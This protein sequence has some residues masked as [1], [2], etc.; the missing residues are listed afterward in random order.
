MA[1]VFDTAGERHV[2]GASPLL[3]AA[4]RDRIIAWRNGRGIRVSE[5]LDDIRKVAGQL[6]SAGCAINLCE[7]RYGFIVAFCAVASK[8]QATLLPTSRAN[9]AIAD[10]QSDHPGA[11]LVGDASC[12]MDLPNLIRLPELGHPAFNEGAPVPM[13]EDARIVAIGFTSGSTG[14]PK[15][16]TK[17]WGNFRLSSA[18]NIDAIHAATGLSAAQTTHVLATVPAQHMYGMEMSVLLPLFGNFAVHSGKAFF[19]ADVAHSLAQM[20]EPRLLVTTPVHLRALLHSAVELPSITAFI[21]ATAPLTAELANEVEQRFGAPVIELFGSTETCV[22]A[23]RRTAS[24]SDWN[25]YPNVELVAQADGTRVEASHLSQPT[26]LQDILELRSR[27]RFRL[28][29]RNADLLEI[30]GKRASL[31]DLTHRLLGLDGVLDAVVFQVDA[32]AG[33]PVRRIAALAVAPGRSEKEL[34]GA[35]RKL[36]DPV[37]LP[38]PLRLVDAL[39]RNETGKLPRQALISAISES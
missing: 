20:P 26:L 10:V 24:E 1:A 33:S 16:N 22:I 31:A 5:F 8:G 15:P 7:D 34:L 27:R 2:S 32:D 37:F 13:I 30:A 28:Q 29:G 21:S 6:P 12:C 36:I 9:Q 14:L 19:P 3:A 38:R 4:A 18:N 17:S 39:P 11:Y 23:H 35:M 25:L